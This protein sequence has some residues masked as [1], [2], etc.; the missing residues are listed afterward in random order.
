MNSIITTKLI[1]PPISQYFNANILSTP[2]FRFDADY[3]LKIAKMIYKKILS[4]KYRKFP[5]TIHELKKQY[6]VFMDLY[7]RAKIQERET[8][9]EEFIKAR[10]L[11]Y[12]TRLSKQDDRSI[13]RRLENHYAKAR[14]G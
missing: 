2:Y 11:F 7:E 1:P 13:F 4:S 14:Y 8:E 3:L 5:A 12:R 9:K 10:M 6:T